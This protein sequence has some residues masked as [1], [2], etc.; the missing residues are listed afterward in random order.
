MPN[1]NI[2]IESVNF[3]HLSKNELSFF[4]AIMTRMHHLR[5]TGAIFNF[6][7]L[8]WLPGDDSISFDDHLQTVVAHLQQTSATYD[9][10][11]GEAK[12]DFFTKV[13]IVNDQ[14]M[15]SVQLNPDFE[16]LVKVDEAHWHEQ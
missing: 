1:D 2:K 6:D 5:T 15:V 8:Q 10:G 3:A 16:F 13:Q 14:E 9:T 12:H 7:E 4:F 11:D